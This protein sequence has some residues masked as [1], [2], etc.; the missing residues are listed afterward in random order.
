MEIEY[1]YSTEFDGKRRKL[2]KFG[3]ICWLPIFHFK[4]RVYCKKTCLLKSKEKLICDFCVKSFWRYPSKIKNSKSGFQ[5]CS[6]KCKE[7]AQS[8]SDFESLRP[9]HYGIGEFNYRKR[10]L[11]FYGSKCKQCNYNEHIQMLDVDHIDGN[12]KNNKLEN[13][14]V[15]CVWCHALKTRGID[16]HTPIN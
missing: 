14:Q 10:A 9:N 11:E 4:N 15:L 1:K 7:E 8:V 3:D 12:R 13:L 16:K 6:R 2:F 5:F